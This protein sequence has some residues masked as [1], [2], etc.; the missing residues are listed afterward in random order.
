MVERASKADPDSEVSIR[1]SP[2]C[3]MRPSE[4]QIKMGSVF[5]QLDLVE[6]RI[7]DLEATVKTIVGCL[8]KKVRFLLP[9]CAFGEDPP[10]RYVVS[11]TRDPETVNERYFHRSE[12]R[13]AD[14]HAAR[15]N[16]L[17]HFTSVL[18]DSRAYVNVRDH[19]LRTPL[20]CVA[21]QG[22]VTDAQRLLL[23][24]AKVDA[25]DVDGYTPL[26]FA[27]GYGCWGLVK[28]LQRNGA[29]PNENTL[30]FAARCGQ[31]DMLQYFLSMVPFVDARTEK[32]DPLIVLAAQ[33]CQWEL[34]HLLLAKGASAT[35]CSNDENCALV[36][37]AFA[38]Q[39][40]A[41]RDILCRGAA[42]NARQVHHALSC[43]LNADTV[44]AFAYVLPDEVRGR[45]GKWAL[46]VAGSR[47]RL[48]TLVAFLEAGVKVNA[49]VDFSGTALHAAAHHGHVDCV[50]E[51]LRRGADGNV[52][53]GFGNT[54]LHEAAL[55]GRVECVRE[56]LEAGA[57]TAVTNEQGKTPFDVAESS[58]VRELL[59]RAVCPP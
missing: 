7:S 59:V 34:V 33:A 19:L 52:K 20:H 35:K 11:S 42:S 44:R 53:D 43:C 26:D 30:L 37:A 3:R 17:E 48:E 50:K 46:L 9:E 54:P 12:N 23:A 31:W 49:V 29:K 18:I 24:G 10:L 32:G 58:E 4:M 41:V 14:L 22:L 5:I 40:D 2:L 15:T 39:A 6:H 21:A 1:S 45:S 28:L 55:R 16:G 36:W 8:R 13:D 57:S 47:G 27:A 38:G 56:L 25:K 51:L